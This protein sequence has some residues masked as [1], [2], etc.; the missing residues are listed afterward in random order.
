V[1]RFRSRSRPHRRI[2]D[3]ASKALL[4]HDSRFVFHA[5]EHAAHVRFEHYVKAFVVLFDERRKNAFRACVVEREPN[6]TKSLPRS[7]RRAAT[8]PRSSSM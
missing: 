8:R 4:Q 3:N 1:T 7:Q 5:V 2:V 6:W